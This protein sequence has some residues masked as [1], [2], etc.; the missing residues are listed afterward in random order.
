VACGV[1]ADGALLIRT[2]AGLQRVLSGD[3][4]VRPQ[5]QDASA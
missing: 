3:V 1:D 5:A 4:S 2:D